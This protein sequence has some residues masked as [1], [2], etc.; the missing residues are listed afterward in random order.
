MKLKLSCTLELQFVAQCVCGGYVYINRQQLKPPVLR[1]NLALGIEVLTFFVIIQYSYKYF[2][3]QITELKVQFLCGGL[4]IFVGIKQRI[5]F[6]IFKL[7]IISRFTAIHN[8]FSS[9]TE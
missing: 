6:I 4:K 1:I 3:R 9:N 2:M 8:V 5:Y 7:N